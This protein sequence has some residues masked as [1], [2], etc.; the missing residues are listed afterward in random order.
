MQFLTDRNI[1]TMDWPA[2]SPD[3]NPIENVCVGVIAREVCKH[4]R[5]YKTVD[6][7]KDAIQAPWD[8]IAPELLLK[9]AGSMTK[10]CIAVVRSK[11]AKISY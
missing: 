4:G 10:R 1:P 3:L 2:L 6:A 5:Q 11:G 8:D 7:L 9:L